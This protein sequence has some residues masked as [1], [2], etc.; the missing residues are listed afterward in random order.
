MIG[1]QDPLSPGECLCVKRSASNSGVKLKLGTAQL[2]PQ[3]TN[4]CII[5]LSRIHAHHT[6]AFSVFT[7][8]LVS[9]NPEG[10]GNNHEVKHSATQ[11][12]VPERRKKALCDTGTH[13]VHFIQ[14]VLAENDLHVLT[15]Q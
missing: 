11:Y 6:S 5:I 1:M 14:N 13:S 15:Y 4:N 12:V 10:Q 2:S 7:F 9:A 8:A 3:S